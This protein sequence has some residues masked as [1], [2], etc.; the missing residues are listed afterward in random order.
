MGKLKKKKMCHHNKSNRITAL[1]SIYSGRI[2]ISYIFMI[3]IH[4]KAE[5]INSAI[6]NKALSQK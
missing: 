4:I 1:I 5:M 2:I 3:K 6:P